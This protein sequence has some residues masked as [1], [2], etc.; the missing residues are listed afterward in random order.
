MTLDKLAVVGGGAWGT[1]LAQVAA[2]GG[3]D[4]MVWAIEEDVVSAINRIHENPVYLQGQK[5]NP[6]IRATSNFSDL[7]TC[8]AWLVVTP[9]QH[10]RAVLDGWRPGAP[11]VLCAKGI[12][13]GT[14]LLPTEIL[15][16]A[17][18]GV[19]AA[20][21][22]GP[23]FAHEVA[24]GLPAA[25]VVAGEDAALRDGIAALRVT[26]SPDGPADDRFPADTRHALLVQ[27]EQGG[28]G[29]PGPILA[30][31]RLD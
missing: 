29:M 6:A 28:D 12:E 8:D 2:A 10:M 9:A 15:H 30:A 26:I 21:L 13:T 4:T 24:A 1:A 11:V 25:A 20:V 22:T 31:I 23:T 19:P 16:D 14:G 17:H 5:L 7:S 18:P 27:R 3:R